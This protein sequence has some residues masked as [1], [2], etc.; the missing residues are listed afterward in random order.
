[1]GNAH[2]VTDLSTLTSWNAEWT[3]LRVAVL[4]LGVTGFAA[5]DTLVELGA[6]VLVVASRAPAEQA[7]LLDVIGASLVQRADLSTVPAEL[8]EHEPELIVVSPG[9]HPD[10]PLLLWA[11]GRGI[12]VWGDIELAWR[13]RD[14]VRVADWIAI[15]GTN[16]KTT[17]AQLTEHLIAASGARVAAVGNIGIPV[18]DA[19]REPTGFDV[20]VVE[21]SSY[22][23]H[24]I[25][26]TPEGSI[27][28]LASVCLNLADDHVDWHGTRE[29]YAAAKGKVYDNTRVA[30]IYNKS[31]VATQRMV[32]DADVVDGCRAIGFDLGTPGPS[33]F[34]LVGD[35]VVD[36]A[37]HDDRR[38]SALELTTHGELATAGL[39][40]PHSVANVLA[41][42][43]LARAY[44]VDP[45][46][47]RAAIS[48]FRM[49][50]HRTE[51]II[52]VDDVQWV[53]DS[54]ATN[55]HAANASLCAYPS[56]VWIVGGLL[57]GV[58]IGDL[59]QKHES[60]LRAAVVIGV[61]RE[62]V[63]AAFARHAPT[64]TV[65]EVHATDTKEVMPEAVRRAAEVARAGDVVLLAPAAAS[66]DQ[67]ADYGDRGRQFAA[68]ARSRAN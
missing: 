39:A 26:S 59:V 52:S 38:N 1:M 30:C 67:F 5:A 27:S 64:L 57:K 6:S 56:V 65:L 13:V 31:D 58:D 2:T 42:T 15:T 36:R 22:Q 29:A 14:K 20:L 35:I 7:E 25:N 60:R 28:P 32:E 62:P 46:I 68:A 50:H 53:D 24:W 44:G 33:D 3:G 34:G 17:T 51:F 9:F 45:A 10:H 47:I 11:Q 43:A 18:L 66:M 19:V 63:L 54:K 55:P 8:E 61:D 21:L 23:L 16:G 41:A 49:D 37:F 4:G 40:A 48:T 12:S